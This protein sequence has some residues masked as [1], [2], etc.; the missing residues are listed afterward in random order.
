MSGWKSAFKA[1]VRRPGTH[2]RGKGEMNMLKWFNNKKKDNKG[3][4]IVELIIVVAIMA[5]LVGLL[6]PQYIKYVEKSRKSADATN[7]DTL[8]NAVQVRAADAE[9]DIP[10]GTYTITLKKDAEPVFKKDGTP[11]KATQGNVKGYQFVDAI[12]ENV[13]DYKSVRLKSNKWTEDPTAHITVTKDGSTT[14][15]YSGADFAEFID[16]TA[17]SNK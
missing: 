8:V 16:K 4:S 15:T 13:A 1:G 3:F 6:A 2:K 10:V 14:I 9:T 11:V 7:M 5:I 17:S 12:A